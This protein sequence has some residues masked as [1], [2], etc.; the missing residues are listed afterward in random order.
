MFDGVIQDVRYGLRLIRK[1]PLLSGAIMATL[2]LGIGLDAGAF[3]LLDGMLFRTRASEQPATFV[4]LDP[5]GTQVR[6]SPRARGCRW[7]RFTDYN[8]YRDRATSLKAVA[9]WT[10]ARTTLTGGPAASAPQDVVSLLVTC[11]FFS[12]YPTVALAGRVFRPEECAEPGG[13]P[14]VLIGEDLWRGRFE[15]DPD[16]VGK[17]VD[18]NG[19][20]FTVVGVLSSAYRWTAAG[21]AV[22][23]L[24]DAVGVFR[25][26]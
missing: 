22:D 1:H 11:N 25:G 24:H 6:D 8:A 21:I 17:T 3:T 14:V 2:A 5:A 13:S 4:Q 16:I 7:S 19:R 10:P 15:S 26:P 9:A 20:P 23:S 12:V 18:L